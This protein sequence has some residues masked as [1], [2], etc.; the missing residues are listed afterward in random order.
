MKFENYK[1]VLANATKTQ[2]KEFTKSVKKLLKENPYQPMKKKCIGNAWFIPY[3]PTS[4]LSKQIGVEDGHNYRKNS[5]ANHPAT[6]PEK[7]PE[8]CI[9]LS[10]VSKGSIIYDPF[11]GTGTTMIAALKLGMKTIGTD[12]SNDYIKFIKKRILA[13][14]N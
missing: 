12:I 13:L 8:Q 2:K 10:G 1:A 9:K 6:F 3:T 11:V 7:L 4:K 14:K 5:R